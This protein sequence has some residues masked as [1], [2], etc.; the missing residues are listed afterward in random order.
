MKGIERY[1]LFEF[2]IAGQR[3]GNPFADHFIKAS[4]ASEFEKKHVDGFYDGDGIYKV[5]FM[6]SYTGEYRFVVA[7]DFLPQQQEGHFFVHPCGK[8]NHGLVRVS[9]QYHFSYEDGTP[10]T[11]V[12]TTC[13]VW[14]HQ[15]EKV[16]NETLSTLEST[17][18]NKLRFCVFPKH[19]KFNFNEP[20]TYPYEG[21]ACDSNFI[22]RRNFKEYLP[23][24]P[25]NEWDFYRF[26]PEHFRRIERAIEQLNRLEIQADLILFHP[27]DR[28][29]FSTMGQQADLFFVRYVIARFAAY[30]NVWWSLANEF[31]LCTDKTEQDWLALAN[32]ICD[33]D[34]YAH[35]R[36]IHNCR[37]LYDYSRAWVTHCSIQRTEVYT[38]AANALAWRE[39]FRKPVVLDEVGYEGDIDLGWGNLLPQEMVRL[40]WTAAVRG[41]YCGH[42]ETYNCPENI[43]WW[44]HGGT[45]KGLSPTRIGFLRHFMETQVP[46]SRLEPAGLPLWDDNCATA[47]DAKSKGRFFLAYCGYTQ[48]SFREFFFDN[49]TQ[50]NVSVIDTWNMTVENRGLHTGWFS[51]DLPTRPYMAI[52]LRAR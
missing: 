29:G 8:D 50:W 46:G 45:L 6:P 24:N 40:F 26:V 32:E 48:P 5:R 33:K 37:Y 41:S 22:T 4:F 34:P 15:P 12:G 51:I 20:E 49:T 36:S 7:A 47:V 31:D 17:H 27:Y 35:L 2:E 14:T 16:R 25:Q 1:G 23:S 44:S 18:F 9:E 21:K 42:S 52:C 43:L 39:R 30:R 10:Y 11:P 3:D 13:Y 19:Y 38:S 28:W